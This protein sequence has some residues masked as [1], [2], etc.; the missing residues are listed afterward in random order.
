LLPF[1]SP[2]FSPFMLDSSVTITGCLLHG[3]DVE[4]DEAQAAHYF[5]LCDD[6]G[7]PRARFK[8]HT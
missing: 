4:M 7:H 5:K 8:Y 3:N 6:H 2:H 1:I